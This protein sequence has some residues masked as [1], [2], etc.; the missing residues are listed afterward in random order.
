M[1]PLV[2]R[3]YSAYAAPLDRAMCFSSSRLPVC[4]TSM[5]VMYR[6]EA[7]ST[8]PSQCEHASSHRPNHTAAS[9]KYSLADIIAE[10]VRHHPGRA[11]GLVRTASGKL[12]KQAIRASL[13]SVAVR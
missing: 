8:R 3:T 7:T 10:A 9:P 13:S 12:Q 1:K 5:F 4:L 11:T 6:G 2:R